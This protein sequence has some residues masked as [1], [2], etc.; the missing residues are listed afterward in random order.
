MW[1]KMNDMLHVAIERLRYLAIS[2]IIHSTIVLSSILH[3][4][5]Y[6]GSDGR[7]DTARTGLQRCLML[8]DEHLTFRFPRREQFWWWWSFPLH[9]DLYVPLLCRQI[10]FRTISIARTERALLQSGAFGRGSQMFSLRPVISPEHN[11]AKVL[12]LIILISGIIPN[13]RWIPRR[14]SNVSVQ[15]YFGSRHNVSPSSDEAT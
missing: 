12:R 9:L 13:V 4:Q 14:K 15:I 2:V 1:M 7:F 3:L 5:T 6:S 10:V 11:F 8:Q